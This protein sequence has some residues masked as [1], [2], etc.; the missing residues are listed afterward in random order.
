MFS[1]WISIVSF[2]KSKGNCFGG[3]DE[4]HHW[5]RRQLKEPH[6][7]L[8]YISWSIDNWQQLSGKASEKQS[9]ENAR[10]IKEANVNYTKE[11]KYSSKLKSAFII[12]DWVWSGLNKIFWSDS[13]RWEI[14]YF[15]VERT[16]PF[17]S[18]CKSWTDFWSESER[19]VAFA[20]QGTCGYGELDWPIL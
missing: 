13:F 4:G 11:K 14:K 20:W 7:M 18:N 6:L 12:C 8:K 9:S 1:N 5:E 15:E 17:L 16:H 10:K 3:D 19:V 2:L